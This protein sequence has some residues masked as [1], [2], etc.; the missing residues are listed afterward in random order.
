MTLLI[1]AVVAIFFVF[2]IGVAGS[3]FGQKPKTD[4]PGTDSKQVSP[5][6]SSAAYAELLLRK[7]EVQSNL[8]SLVLE[9]TEEYPKV[10]ELRF[11]LGL[12]DRDIA[13]LGQVKMADAGKLTL[14]L[15]KLIVRR[16][17]LETDLWNLQRSYK[18]EHPEVKRAKRKVEIYEAAI[19]EILN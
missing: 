2:S 15:G 19:S 14:A 3:T 6:S 17:E 13:R 16:I 9:Y 11:V 8:E 18:D 1:K 7:T 5:V 10:K 4:K 12:I